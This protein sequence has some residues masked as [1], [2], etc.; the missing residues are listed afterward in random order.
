MMTKKT[1]KNGLIIIHNQRENSK[2]V[3][4]RLV[5]KAGK[6]YNAIYSNT[7]G[8]AHFLEHVVHEKTEKYSSKS[9]LVSI[10]E[11][12]GGVRN[13]ATSNTEK[14]IFFA[15]VLN[16]F[17][18]NAFDYISQ[19]AFHSRFDDKSVIKHKNIIKEELLSTFKKSDIKVRNLFESLA[20]QNTEFIHHTL[21]T[22]E[23][24]ESIDLDELKNYYKTRFTPDNSILCV[25]G[26]ISLDKCEEFVNRYFTNIPVNE[27]LK[28][29]FDKDSVIKI[30][31]ENT[32]KKQA[33][34]LVQDK[35][36]VIN[37]G[38][39]YIRFD[40]SQY[41]KQ[42]VLLGVLTYSGNSILNKKLREE[43]NIVYNVSGSINGNK[44]FGS[45][46]FTLNTQSHNIQKSLDI[47]KEE[48]LKISIEGVKIDDMNRTKKIIQ[49]REVFA[50]Q[51]VHA[52]A[53][54]DAD[55]QVS[56]NDLKN[57]E[58]WLNE[59][60]KIS[61]DDI[62]DTAKWLHDNLNILAVSSNEEGI[63]Y[64]F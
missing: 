49:T 38:A 56:F 35:Q 20:Y 41:F 50:N 11:N 10:V 2:I 5:V 48:L 9:E 21:G 19:I 57:S 3:D 34:V 51:Q 24:I 22:E 30:I 13:A 53:F 12:Y 55:I 32:E 6:Y 18:E 16:D 25:S 58:D 47:I 45:F 1:L 61:D 14:M 64:E 17:S 54:K 28:E 31:T 26:D 15:T 46:Y 42:L 43:N 23:S 36:A 44:L 37:F 52:E 7:P 60:M 62:K 59:I 33:T 63:K 29:T 39:K 40:D 8:L 27:S 4:V